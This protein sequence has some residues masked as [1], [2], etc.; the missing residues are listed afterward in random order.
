MAHL[1]A[2]RLFG[3]LTP[4]ILSEASSK[5]NRRTAEYRI[6]NVEGWIRFAQSLIKQ[7]AYITSTFDVHYSIFDIRFFRNSLPIWLAVVQASG[8]ADT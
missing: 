4:G 1:H 7:T 5:A 2:P 6:T 8:W 3:Y